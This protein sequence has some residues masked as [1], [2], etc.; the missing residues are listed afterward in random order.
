MS[1]AETA[2]LAVDLTFKSNAGTVLGGVNKQLKGLEASAAHIQKGFSRMGAGIGNV[3]RGSI[4]L[5]ERGALALGGALVGAAKLAAEFGDQMNVI[6]TIAQRTPEGLA[7]IGEGIRGLAR[8]TGADLTDLTGAYY[9]LLS[10]GIK[11]ADSQNALSLAY[12]LSRGSLSTT[13]EAVDFLTTAINSYR[14]SQAQT[15]VVADQ[16]AQAVADGKVKMSEISATFANVASIAKT[17]GIGIEEIAAAYGHL[18]AQGIPAAEVTTEMNRAIIELLKP[19]KDL[20]ELQDDTGKS[21]VALASKIGLVPALQQMRI[22]AEKAG[23]PFQKLFGRLEG[24]KFALQTTGPEFAKFEAEQNR[25]TNS[26]GALSKQVGER[27][28]GLAF[29][30]GRLKANVK[31]AGISIGQG[32]APQLSDM[33]DKLSTF[34]GANKDNLVGLGK[35]I[36]KAFA[37]IDWA[38]MAQ[39]VGSFADA[40]KLAAAPAKLIFDAFMKLPA[41]F[42]TAIIAGL[43]ANKLSGGLLGKGLG[44]IISG[45]AEGIGGLLMSRGSSPANPL[46]VSDVTGGLGGGTVEKA[47]GGISLAALAAGAAVIAGGLITTWLSANDL[48]DKRNAIA[49]T[50]NLNNT[51]ALAVQL[52]QMDP[53]NRQMA[54]IHGAQAEF[55]RQGTTYE[56]ALASA[57]DAVKTFTQNMNRQG[58]PSP[59]NAAALAAQAAIRQRAIEHGK[60]PTESGIAATFALNAK[61]VATGNYDLRPKGGG[62]VSKAD[63]GSAGVMERAVAKGFHPTASGITATLAKNAAKAAASTRAASMLAQMT[64]IRG[65]SAYIAG[66]AAIVAAVKGIAAPVV[67]VY[68]NTSVSTRDV[69]IKSRTTAS[70]G[71]IAAFGKATGKV[72]ATVQ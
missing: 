29:Q 13:G 9:D 51:Q 55:T 66:S 48:R 50:G 68:T 58:P 35:D 8:T 72:G 69:T 11:V 19:A 15:T 33:V 2:K 45:G 17:A 52:S 26:A 53:A 5:A 71:R 1:M 31:D 21:Y 18:T 43:A 24:Y 32:F 25:I 10:A 57:T 59:A 7:A 63:P 40:L 44:Q 49:T 38:K 3:M 46:F 62:L 37:G 28:Q 23:I 39:G 41:G 14:L 27:Q 42:Q 54:L 47:V 67:N 20:R 60:T 65:V 64:A 36:G 34:I 4:V 61:A 16:F 22:D 12:Q 56:K 6:N 30:F 70:Y